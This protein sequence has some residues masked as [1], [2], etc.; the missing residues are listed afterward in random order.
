MAGSFLSI[1]TAAV[2]CNFTSAVMGL[3]VIARI[4]PRIHF[5]PFQ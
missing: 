4:Q 2:P 3:G 1:K 5:R